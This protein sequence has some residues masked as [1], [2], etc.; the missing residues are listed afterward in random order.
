VIVT[1]SDEECLEQPSPEESKTTPK[2]VELKHAENLLG[3]ISAL[4]NDA[5]GLNRF[6]SRQI[7]FNCKHP[8]LL[9][10]KIPLSSAGG[11]DGNCTHAD[12]RRIVGDAENQQ[13]PKFGIN[14]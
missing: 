10:T 8:H 2:T 7:R 9:V 12:R 11:N 13:L 14:D 3:M 5:Q 4:A 6:A 1:G